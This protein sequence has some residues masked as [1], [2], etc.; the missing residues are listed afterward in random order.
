MSS[1]KANIPEI[2][3]SELPNQ[4][5]KKIL[6]NA[7]EYNEQTLNLMIVGESGL[8]KTTFINTLFQTT[9]KP[10]QG[11][12][13]REGVDE[14]SKKS[15]NKTTNIE[16]IRCLLEEKNF[17]LKLNLIDTPGYGD[18]IN[19]SK[20]WLPLCDFVDEQ[21]DHYMRQEQQPFRKAKFDL[22]VHAVI[23]FIRPTNGTLKPLDV[24]TM[25]ELSKK[26]NLIPVIAKSDTLNREELIQ[27]KAKIRKVIEEQ[28]IQI[29]T[30]PIFEEEN[31]FA[32]GDE[33]AASN[34][35]AA[36]QHAKQL[37][38]SMPFAIIGSEEQYEINGNKV[39]GRKYP[40]G[41]IEVENETHCDFRKLRSLL[42]RTNLLDLIHSTNDFHYEVYR[43][44]RL[45][46]NNEEN[47]SNNTNN[48]KGI[49]ILPAPVR[50]M[51]HNPR[52]KE[53]ELALKRYFTEQVKVE[54]Q[55]FRQWEQNIVNERIRLNNDLEEEQNKVK[56][57]EDQIRVLQMK[58]K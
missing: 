44:T 38:D 46:A 41:L 31:S 26:S 20:A 28:N 35:R 45:Q 58:S 16:I 15:S 40:W 33:D 36:I 53:E 30:P 10:K 7:S 1:V 34:N 49:N 25:G 52:F 13:E 12:Y 56:K 57:L 9:L 6:T 47:N 11:A 14:F 8:G 18:F 48:N 17:T 27:F 21:Y 37:V 54:E 24:I 22:R 55:R 5:Y 39:F 2:G 29:F 42:L 51:S 4:V 50:K 43:K 32:A 3:I 23:F 19:N